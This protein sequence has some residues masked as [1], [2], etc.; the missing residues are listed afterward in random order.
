[1]Y[2]GDAMGLHGAR[3]GQQ[4]TINRWLE[5]LPLHPRDPF[6]R[7]QHTQSD[8]LDLFY[9]SI[10][11]QPDHFAVVAPQQNRQQHNRKERVYLHRACTSRIHRL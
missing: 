11:L 8:L 1:M 10:C 9:C 6:A 3:N 5:Q 4:A 2:G 7:T